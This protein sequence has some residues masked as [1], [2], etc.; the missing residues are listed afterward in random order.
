MKRRTDL[1]GRIGLASTRALIRN[2]LIRPATPRND[3]TAR[4]LFALVDGQSTSP[5]HTQPF[6]TVPRAIGRR[7]AMPFKR[8]G[9]RRQRP[10]RCVTRQA[11]FDFLHDAH[12]ATYALGLPARLQ[13][14]PCSALRGRSVSPRRSPRSTPIPAASTAGSQSSS[15][16]VLLDAQI[17]FHISLLLDEVAWLCPVAFTRRLARQTAHGCRLGFR[18]R[19]NGIV[20]PQSTQMP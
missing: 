17:A 5:K 3:P 1:L 18:R 2:R 12:A 10:H 16:D 15:V 14:S 9:P 8:H 4:R 19:K 11:N 6:S 20:S 13:A 7:L